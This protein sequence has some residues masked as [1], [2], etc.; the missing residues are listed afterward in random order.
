MRQTMRP[1]MRPAILLTV[2]LALL[3]PAATAEPTAIDVHVISRGAKFIGSSMGGV[4]ITIRDAQS[5]AILAEGVTA[6][7]TGSTD[8][9]MRSEH[10]RSPLL[11]TEDAG[12]FRTELDIERP[13]RLEIAAFGPLAQRQSAQEVTATAWVFPG[14]DMA[15]GNGFLLEMPGLSVDLLSPPA[16]LRRA[17]GPIDIAANVTMMC[18]C[19]LTP[20]GLWDSDEFAITAVIRRDG[21]EVALVPLSY[22][23]SASQFAGRFEAEEPGLYEIAVQAIQ[24]GLNNTGVDFA[25]IIV[26]APQ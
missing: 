7:T 17:P 10:G 23:G 20:E 22:A 4:A 26:A 6:G 8:R 24:P 2:F 21:R 3:A 5:G 13:T 19:P 25:H 11:V 18:G 14:H 1:A 12:G 16:H 15:G 9:I